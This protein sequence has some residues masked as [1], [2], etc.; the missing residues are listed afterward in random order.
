MKKAYITPTITI[1]DIDSTEVIC[2]SG[3]ARITFDETPVDQSNY[4]SMF[5]V[6]AS[7]EIVAGAGGYRSSLW[8]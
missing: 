2:V 4:R 1:I 8:D 3:E 7:G 5:D 6:S